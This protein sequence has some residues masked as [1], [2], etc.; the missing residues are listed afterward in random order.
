MSLEFS[1]MKHAD[2][3]KWR[4]T[5]IEDYAKAKV[6][7]GSW[8]KSE[9]LEN[10]MES[11]ATLLPKGLA[12]KGHFIGWIMSGDLK[13]GYT[14]LACNEAVN[15]EGQG[16]VY[17]LFI[18][19]EHRG[20]GYGKQAMDLIEAYFKRQAVKKIGLNVF[21][22]NHPA[23]ALYKKCEYEIGSIQMVKEIR[24]SNESD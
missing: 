15:T 11:Y 22:Y 2:Y 3:D 5:S 20:K 8:K 24:Y 13:I 6:K 4:Q 7:S 21:G 18:D 1:R 10:A 16:W 9:S 12:T 19:D 23:I 14:W 17:E